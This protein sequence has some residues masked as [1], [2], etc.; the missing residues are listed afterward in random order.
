[1]NAWSKKS[2][3]WYADSINENS[4]KVLF[5]LFSGILNF[6]HEVAIYIL[7]NCV[8]LIAKERDF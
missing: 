1:M 2:V 6:R 4:K 3:K 7:E 5:I 8:F